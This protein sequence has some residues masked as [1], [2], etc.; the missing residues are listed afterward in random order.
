MTHSSEDD[1]VET[2]KLLTGQRVFK[3]PRKLKN[4]FGD[5]DDE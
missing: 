1:S 3:G 2:E 4:L 5:S